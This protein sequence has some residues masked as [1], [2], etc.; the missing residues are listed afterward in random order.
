MTGRFGSLLTAM[1]TP[2]DTDGRL[3]VDGA[4][5]LARHLVAQGN[6]GLVLAGTTGESPV[7]TDEEKTVLWRAVAE[8]VTV[9]V[10]AGSGTY[11]TAHSIELT[12][13]AEACGAA[14]ILAVCPYYNRPSQ[15]GLEA[16]FRAV[17]GATSLPVM[18]YD[19]PIRTGRRIEG[20]VLLRLARDVENVV[21]VKDAGNDVVAAARLIAAAPDGFDLYS[22]DDV[23]T[24]PL[25]SVGAVGA[26]SV[27]A[28]WIAPQLK[29][30]IT[31]F[32]AGDPATARRRNAELLDAVTFQTND[33]TPNPVPAKAMLRELGLPAGRCRLPHIEPPEANLAGRARELISSLGLAVPPTP[34][35]T[36]AGA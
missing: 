9:P 33:E 35:T 10:I 23:L 17:A 12:K 20:P 29:E 31:A 2:F 5:T 4:V 15:A 16:H 13:T 25:L 3:D 34:G 7:L 11:D 14:G 22:G 8:A 21:A 36:P 19:I 6:D 18:L 32:L 30:M 28:H 1:V 27:A 24:L 26:V